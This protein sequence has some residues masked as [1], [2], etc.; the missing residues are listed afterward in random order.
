MKKIWIGG[1]LGIALGL[2]QMSAQAK[3]LQGI[4]TYVSDGD[5]LW[6]S[7]DPKA[8][9]IKVRLQG[10]DAPEI[11]QAWGMQARDALKSRL[12]KQ[13]VSLKTRAKDDYDR[14]LG[15][16]ALRG[17]DIGEWLVKNGHA[18]SYHYRRNPGPYAMEQAAAQSAKLGLWAQSGAQEPRQFRKAHGSCKN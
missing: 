2:L 4:V 18:W 14:A 1:L 11:C 16:V 3:I 9:P 6:I 5:T 12:L 13:S 8:K 7:V 15:Q 17:E 10:I